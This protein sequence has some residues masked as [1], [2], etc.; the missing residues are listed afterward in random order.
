MAQHWRSVTL[1]A[2]AFSLVGIAPLSALAQQAPA[3]FVASPDV[4]KVV[5]ENA[6]FRVIEGT[7]KPGQRDVLHTHPLPEVTY[8]IT[9]CKRRSYG[10]DGSVQVDGELAQG[11][12]TVRNSHAA[13]TFENTGATECRILF[14]ERK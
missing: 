4:Y 7:W 11:T 12:V 9:A 13:H 2:F 8:A 3:S 14:V 5:A 6:Q 10:P 1:S